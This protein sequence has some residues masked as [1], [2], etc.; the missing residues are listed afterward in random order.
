MHYKDLF[1]EMEEWTESKSCKNP[2]PLGNKLLWGILAGNHFPSL[3]IKILFCFFP[4]FNKNLNKLVCVCVYLY[5]CV[6]VCVC[7]CEGS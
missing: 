6:C 7:V 2:L 3:I 5:V 1:I 4:S